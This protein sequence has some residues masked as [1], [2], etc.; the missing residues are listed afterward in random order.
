MKLI[1]FIF[2]LLQLCNGEYLL[3]NNSNVQYFDIPIGGIFTSTYSYPSNGFG[4]SQSFDNNIYFISSS[5]QYNYHSSNKNHMC[6][7]SKKYVEIMKFD[8]IS[9]TFVDS[10]LIGDK[11][12]TY[13]NAVGGK[14]ND[15]I[16]TCGIDKKHNILFY[17]GN[18]KFDCE[19]NYNFDTSIV[20]VNIETFTFIDRTIIKNL[21]NI[22][23]FSSSS[24]YSYKY[25]NSLTTSTILDGDSLWLGFGTYYTGILKLDITTPTIKILDK[26]QKITRETIEDP[27]QIGNTYERIEYFNNIKKSFTLND[28]YVYFIKDDRVSDSKILKIKTSIPISVNNSELIILDG[29]NNINDIAFNFEDKKIYIIKGS[30]TS[31]LYQY[32]FNFNKIQLNE[33][34]NVDFLKFPTKWGPITKIEYNKKT[35]FLYPIISTRY[36]QNGFSRINTK[37]LTLDLNY[38]KIFGNHINNGKNYG[39]YQSYHNFNISNINIL[40]GQMFILPNQNG[41]Y[42]KKIIN[43]SLE[44]C[45]KGRGLENNTCKKC[46]YGKYSDVIGGICKDC[47][48]GFA[49]NEIESFFCIKCDSGKYTNGDYSIYCIDCPRGY[50][51]NFDG[52]DDCKACNKGTYSIKLGSGKKDDCKECGPGKISYI[53]FS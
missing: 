34:C 3:R 14:G 48:P 10:L 16:V 50:Y 11:T 9:Q 6:N 42:I 47:S 27:Y 29:I 17:G 51:S 22:P 21:N 7:L 35:G 2:L 33:N 39:Y 12:N 53:L 15:N 13:P 31:E 43:I 26:F 28:G 32:D 38:H 41:G 23:T 4:C 45:A 1:F 20:R 46:K 8:I 24:Y 49:S 36:Q 52:S 18:N 44:G 40:N 37:D 25:I 30:L 5:Y 19:S